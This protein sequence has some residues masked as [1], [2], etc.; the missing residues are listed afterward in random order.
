MKLPPSPSTIT[1]KTT[2]HQPLLRLTNKLLPPADYPLTITTITNSYHQPQSTIA[3][4]TNNHH[5]LHNNFKPASA[6]IATITI[7]H[8]YFPP[9]T[10]V[11]L[12][13]VV[14]I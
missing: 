7:T 11:T 3:T 8:Q 10:N 4:I 2:H 5:H 12:C 13:T 9:L 1:H 6:P 14:I